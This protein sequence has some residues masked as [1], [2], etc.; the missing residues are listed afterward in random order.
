MNEKVKTMAATRKSPNVSG[1]P[2]LVWIGL[3]P[4]RPG[5]DPDDRKQRAGS[6]LGV[7]TDGTLYLCIRDAVSDD[8][9][10]VLVPPE[11]LA[12][13]RS[14]A[15]RVSGETIGTGTYEKLYELC[16]NH[17]HYGPDSQTG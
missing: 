12:A 16:K 4:P 14:R 7:A 10:A 6:W 1:K 13:A 9:H 2:D 17:W 3:G 8:W 5:Y 11:V 15:R